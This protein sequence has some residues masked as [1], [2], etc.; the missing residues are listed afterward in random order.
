M[1]MTRNYLNEMV[2]QADRLDTRYRTAVEQL[3]AENIRDSELYASI[4]SRMRGSFLVISSNTAL[5]LSA[6]GQHRSVN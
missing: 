2:S 3:L 5:S 6:A 1:F 4:F